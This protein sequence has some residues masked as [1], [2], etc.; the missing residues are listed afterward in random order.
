LRT[1][2]TWAGARLPAAWLAAPVT[3][4]RFSRPHTLVGTTASILGI[5]VIAAAELPGVG[6]GDGIADLG[7]TLLAGAAVNV[8]IVGLNQ[9]EDL[10]IDRINKPWL[11]IPSGRLDLRVA[12]LLAIGCGVLAAGLAFTQGWVEVAAVA[13]AL[14]IGTAYSC[15]PLR[16]KRFPAAAAA[17]ISLVRACVVNLGVY[18]HFASSLGGRD[19]LSPLP[20]PIV[21]LTLFV[22]PFSFAIAVLK[23]V[24]DAEGDR[25][26]RIATFTVRLGPRAAFRIGMA[27]LTVGYLGMA[28]L[29][30]LT[31]ESA[32]PW[33]LALGHLACL[34]VLWRL[35][36][37]VD[38][39]DAASFGGFYMRVWALFFLE[40]MLMPV[41]VVAGR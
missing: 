4:W 22:L 6:L 7:L 11:P 27:A 5:Y 20:G 31:L 18:L 9:C 34:A 25:R 36:L 1:V 23:D 8:Y 35:A 16:L 14:A 15:W 19:G 38:P 3:L 12:W 17:S 28:L 24:P 21:A 2:G 10:E 41:A 37:R 40:Y 30:P 26:F 32:S 29:G 13:A 39:A 33:V